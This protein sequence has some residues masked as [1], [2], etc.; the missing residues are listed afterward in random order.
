[1]LSLKT[2]MA[3]VM[4]IPVNAK[5]VNRVESFRR[6]TKAKTAPAINAIALASVSGIKTKKPKYAGSMTDPGSSDPNEPRRAVAPMRR[7]HA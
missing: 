7:K 6:T 5:S 2:A 3:N 1:M 4:T